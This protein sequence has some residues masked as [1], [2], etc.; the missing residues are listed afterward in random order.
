MGDL[1]GMLKNV[2]VSLGREEAEIDVNALEQ[3]TK[4]QARQVRKPPFTTY[5][6][7]RLKRRK[8]PESVIREELLPQPGGVA[9][10]A[11]STRAPNSRHVFSPGA[12]MCLAKVWEC[13]AAYRATSTRAMNVLGFGLRRAGSPE[14]PPQG[15]YVLKISKKA[16]FA[17]TSSYNFSP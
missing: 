2:E 14:P 4:P 9:P 7:L 17:Y 16:G 5:R 1:E 11:T 15:T 6:E 8:R 13:L 10:L 3:M 12:P